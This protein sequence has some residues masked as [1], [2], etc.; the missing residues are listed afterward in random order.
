MSEMTGAILVLSNG[1]PLHGYSGAICLYTG[2][3]FGPSRDALAE[4]KAAAACFN[5]RGDLR[6]LGP[7]RAARV[8][9]TW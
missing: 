5:R 7:V 8:H 3:S 6:S 4:A 2:R 9:L 1:A